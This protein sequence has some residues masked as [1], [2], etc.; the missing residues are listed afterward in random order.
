MLFS[1]PASKLSLV[2]PMV[3]IFHED[4][5]ILGAPGVGISRTKQGNSGTAVD[6]SDS[7]PDGKGLGPS[8]ERQVVTAASAMIA[9]DLVGVQARIG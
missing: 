4:V 3:F 9:P 8:Q 1:V 2:E 7:E 6:F 5:H